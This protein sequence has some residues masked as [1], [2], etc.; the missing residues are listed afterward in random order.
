MRSFLIKLGVTTLSLAVADQLLS[1]IS[2]DSVVALFVAGFFLNLANAFLRPIFV[3]LTLPITVVTFG[4]FLFILNGF[5][6]WLVSSL[7]PS[8]HVASFSEAIFGWMITGI[9]AWVTMI[10]IGEQSL[11]QRR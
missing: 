7:L 10:A 11:Q 9:S 4:F 6:F 8:F 1:G 2:F 5:I 3:I